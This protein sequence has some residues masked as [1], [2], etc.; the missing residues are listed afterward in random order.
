M[1]PFRVEYYCPRQGPIWQGQGYRSNIQ[2]AAMLAQMI[3]PPNGWS[4]IVDAQGFIVGV[5]TQGGVWEWN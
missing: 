2:S 5:L 4:R 3:K 1:P